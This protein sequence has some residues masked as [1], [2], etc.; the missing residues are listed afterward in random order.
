MVA[1]IF[2]NITSFLLSFALIYAITS[3]LYYL[4]NSHCHLL[5][6]SPCSR[7]RPH[8]FYFFDSSPL[9]LCSLLLLVGPFS[10]FFKPLVAHFD[11]S[12]REKKTAG[13]QMRKL[14]RE[15]C[16]RLAWATLRH[17]NLYFFCSLKYCSSLSLSS[18][19]LLFCSSRQVRR[20]QASIEWD[21]M[22]RD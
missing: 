13:E 4:Q 11:P 22:T 9:F 19:C 21:K 2:F 10:S 6:L 3:P 17:R 18:V 7:S 5:Y 15:A 20:C 1:S 16:M 12:S 8:S 14:T